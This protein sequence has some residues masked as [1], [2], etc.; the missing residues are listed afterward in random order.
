MYSKGRLPCWMNEVAEES[1]M[2]EKGRI[3]NQFG[4][5]KI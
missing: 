3:I 1:K 2:A 4:N 5:K